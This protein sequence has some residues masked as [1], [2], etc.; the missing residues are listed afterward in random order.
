MQIHPIKFIKP[1]TEL[2]VAFIFD[3]ELE[4]FK[5]IVRKVNF[6]G[7]DEKGRFVNCWIDYND[8]E[9]VTDAFLYDCDFNLQPCYDAWRFTGTIALLMSLVI[10][11]QDSSSSDSSSDGSCDGGA[12]S[13]SAKVPARTWSEFIYDA[14]PIVNTVMLTYMFAR[15]HFVL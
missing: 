2:E 9:S 10:Q 6:Y 13:A 15:Y 8:G 1:K 11:N 5:G 4:W 7:Y 12:A 3:D 14:L